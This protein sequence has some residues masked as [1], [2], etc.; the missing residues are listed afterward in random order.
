MFSFI[1]IHAS[2]QVTPL[3]IYPPFNSWSQVLVLLVK[4]HTLPEH[5]FT[6]A[7]TTCILHVQFGL[8]T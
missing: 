8:C 3:L 4:S 7:I 5:G 1:F 2:F 6:L